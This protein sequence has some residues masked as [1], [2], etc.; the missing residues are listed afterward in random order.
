MPP[1]ELESSHL[2]APPR[3]VF[4]D[5]SGAKRRRARR[6]GRLLGVGLITYALVLLSGLLRP[7]PFPDADVPP[8][9]DDSPRREQIP[10][11]QGVLLGPA[12]GPVFGAAAAPGAP[13]IV[14]PTVPTS[15][16]VT[17]PAALPTAP[18]TPMWVAGPSTAPP[19][20]EHAAEPLANTTGSSRPGSG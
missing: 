12:P 13:A 7:V 2:A 1:I 14:E 11:A 16:V 20:G 18:P 8:P 19:A 4:V 9:S 17:E 3:S 5:D 10:S 15:P 6:A